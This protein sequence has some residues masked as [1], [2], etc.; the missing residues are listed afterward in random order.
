M[1]PC[2]G[3][4]NHTPSEIDQPA[5]CCRSG[6]GAEFILVHSHT[7]TSVTMIMAQIMLFAAGRTE[8]RHPLQV[9]DHPGTV[10][11]VVRATGRAIVQRALVDLFTLVTDGDF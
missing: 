1:K 2:A 6:C 5:S 10:V 7:G 8:R 4:L 11:D 3:G 9:A